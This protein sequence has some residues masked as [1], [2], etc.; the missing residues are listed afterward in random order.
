MNQVATQL[1]SIQS[2]ID[3]NGILQYLKTTKKEKGINVWIGEA[4]LLVIWDY[5][6]YYEIMD[7][8]CYNELQLLLE[9]K[10]ELK[11]RV[12]VMVIETCNLQKSITGL[13][14]QSA[15]TDDDLE[16]TARK[17]ISIGT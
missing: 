12:P 14:E 7:D 1:P 11:N 9:T 3:N 5:Y 16:L 10:T 8:D 6:K 2:A 13:S 4:P 15:L 17:F